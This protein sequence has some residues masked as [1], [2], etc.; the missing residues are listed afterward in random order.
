[1]LCLKRLNMKGK[2]TDQNNC[3]YN[4]KRLS[5]GGGVRNRCFFLKCFDNLQINDN[6]FTKSLSNTWEYPF[7]RHV[8]N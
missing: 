7:L 6:L 3:V 1:M 5:E 8:I 4:N 2:K